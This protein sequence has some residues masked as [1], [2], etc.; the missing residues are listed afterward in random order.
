MDI[1][2]FRS[3]FTHQPETGRP[4]TAYYEQA[5]VAM[6]GDPCGADKEPAKIF[7][8]DSVFRMPVKRGID[9]SGGK[10]RVG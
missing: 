8:E 6:G 10:D 9:V 5:D 2:P 4:K 7:G 3:K 1:R